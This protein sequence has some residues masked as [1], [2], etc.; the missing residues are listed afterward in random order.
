M[1]DNE[2]HVHENGALLAE[3]KDPE[4]DH[5]AARKQQ[6]WGLLTYMYKVNALHWLPRV[7]IASPAIRVA[8]IERQRRVC[9]NY[10]WTKH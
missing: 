1:D 7:L 8:L 2:P 10:P 6:R 5:S 4:A 9:D 3:E